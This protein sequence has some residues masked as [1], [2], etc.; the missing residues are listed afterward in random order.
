M[1][2]CV[3]FHL[4]SV[5]LLTAT[6]IIGIGCAS[7]RLS[8]FLAIRRVAARQFA[9]IAA[10]GGRFTWVAGRGLGGR[11]TRIAAHGRRFTQ[12]KGW[13]FAREAAWGQ[14][15]VAIIFRVTV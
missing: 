12:V 6:H 13:Q 5:T 14:T 9:Q 4:T 15:Y 3:F 10:H 11:L 1:F 2:A 8:W 7:N